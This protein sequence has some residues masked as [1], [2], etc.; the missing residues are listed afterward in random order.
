MTDSALVGGF[1]ICTSDMFLFLLPLVLL[2][3]ILTL[4]GGF[5]ICL[6]LLHFIKLSLTSS[7][8]L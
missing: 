2:V 7:T 6:S 5:R 3:I 8:S 1:M 4:V